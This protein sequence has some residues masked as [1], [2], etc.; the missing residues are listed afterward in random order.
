MKKR[1][2]ILKNISHEGPGLIKEV[3][4]EYNIQSL[5]I[6]LTKFPNLPPIMNFDLLVVMGG[7]DSAN[8]TS[9]KI[10]NE[11]ESIKSAMNRNI[12]VLGICL[13]LQLMVK[14]KSGE[15]LKNPV[16][17]MG[18]KMN[19]D[20][21]EITLTKKGL[22]DPIFQEIP[23]SF[24]AFHLHGET[25]KLNNGIELLGT[26]KFCENQ[27][28]KI[29][30]YN[31]GFQFHFELTEEMFQEW[32]LKAPEL[33]QADKDTLLHEFNLIK[34]SYTERGRKIIS[35]YLILLERLYLR[36]NLD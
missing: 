24:P 13:G 1:A 34:N 11:L 12:P 20:W 2:L 26:G 15:V 33:I 16:Q 4:D 17:E 30:E 35:N 19:N 10:Q 9:Y 5:I 29:G 27:I 32:L 25:V 21:N 7:P 28:I 3:L 36:D 6:D 23:E 18:F 8:D 22:E 14:A 31:Y